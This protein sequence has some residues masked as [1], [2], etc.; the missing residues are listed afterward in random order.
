[1]IFFGRVLKTPTWSVAV[2]DAVVLMLG[3]PSVM[4]TKVKMVRDEIMKVSV[5]FMLE[6]VFFFLAND[7][8]FKLENFRWKLI[9]QQI[10]QKFF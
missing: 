6:M 5:N 8:S 1:M 7:S 4:P 3:M 10:F 9:W 2:V